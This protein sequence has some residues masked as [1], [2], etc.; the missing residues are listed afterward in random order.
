MRRR[1]L[2]DVFASASTFAALRDAALRAAKGLRG[3]PS[4]AAWLAEL[5]ANTLHLQGELLTGTY[6]PGR[7]QTFRI[8]DPKPRTI[9]VAPFRDRV[10]HHALCAALEPMFDRYADAD[11]F[12]CRRG[13][14]TLRA[15]RRCQVLARRSPWCLRLDVAHYFESVSHDV[16]VALLR[17]RVADEAAL[18]LIQK[19]L[20]A[21]VGPKGRGLPIGNLTSQHFGNFLLGALDHHA[22][23]AL[24]VDGWV[25]YMDDICVFGPSKDALWMVHDG[26]DRYV[27]E[28]LRLELKTLAT[29]VAPTSVGVPFLGFRVWPHLVRL[30]PPARR[31]LVR[32]LRAARRE[33]AS[34]R[35]GIAMLGVSSVVAW[36]TQ[37]NTLALRRSL[38]RLDVASDTA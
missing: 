1:P 6:Q 29:V 32:R 18:A 23:E 25:R 35:D 2:R 4:V 7:L 19:L 38:M 21:G 33:W 37:A 3:R 17:R 13:K 30:G 24:R 5:E 14:G 28:A 12:A 16:L 34:A 31:R 26:L 20:D 11:S 22:R 9:A 10:V 15:V 27:R 8:R 36:A